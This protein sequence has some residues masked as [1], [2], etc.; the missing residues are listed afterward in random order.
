[1]SKTWGG[2]VPDNG[3][4]NAVNYWRGSNDKADEDIHTFRPDKSKPPA[5]PP[6][7]SPIKSDGGSQNNSPVKGHFK[8]QDGVIGLAR[9]GPERRRSITDIR[10]LANSRDY[11]CYTN[12]ALTLLMNL[13][14]FV[15]YLNRVHTTEDEPAQSD[16]LTL[17]DD[18]SRAYWRTHSFSEIEYPAQVVRSYVRNLPAQHS[19]GVEPFIPNGGEEMH[20]DAAD[21]LNK[22][23]EICSAQVRHGRKLFG[24]G[25]GG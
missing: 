4:R 23:L 7:P 22:V 2:Y 20:E 3:N 24:E 5:G 6:F 21:W 9:W 1:M 13:D 16:L 19:F 15:G 8:K 17:L 12:S 25:H 10:G 18:F 14:P 11:L